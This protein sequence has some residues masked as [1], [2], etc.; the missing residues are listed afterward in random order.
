MIKK[1]IG[2]IAIVISVLA[3]VISLAAFQAEDADLGGVFEI[4]RALFE[5][6]FETFSSVVFNQDGED[7]GDVTIEGDTDTTLFF[8]DA[9]EDTVTINRFTQGGGVL[10][11]TDGA[12]I[13]LTQADLDDHSMLV[14]EA[15]TTASTYTLTLPATSTLTTLIPTAGES[16]SWLFKNENTAAGTTTTFVAGT[17]IVLDEPDG[18]NVVIGGG[19]R[20]KLECWRDDNTDVICS[21]DERIDGD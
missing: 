6:G 21:V 4:D 14:L 16:R 11:L 20:A 12:S 17:G 13:T 5:N 8:S 19:N 2:W 7:D 3:L 18:Q 1:Y 9:S 15:S 10:S